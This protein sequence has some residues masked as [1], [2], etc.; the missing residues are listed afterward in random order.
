MSDSDFE[1]G[2]DAEMEDRLRRLAAASR[3]PALPDEIAALPWTVQLERPRTGIFDIA[4]AVAAGVG[5]L[6]RS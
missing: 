5:S 3:T 2:S 1:N 4:P 6:R